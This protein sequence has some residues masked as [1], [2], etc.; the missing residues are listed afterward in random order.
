MFCLF[1]LQQLYRIW[2]GLTGQT[3]ETLEFMNGTLD[4][5]D[6]A[7]RENVTTSMFG[8]YWAS[9]H[10]EY[11]VT[12]LLNLSLRGPVVRNP[13]F[14]GWPPPNLLLGYKY[15]ANMT[16]QYLFD[17]RMFSNFT[18]V[19]EGT[20][21]RWTVLTDCSYTVNTG[22]MSRMLEGGIENFEQA[23]TQIQ[24]AVLMDRVASSIASA[25]IEMQGFGLNHAIALQNANRIATLTGGTVFTEAYKSKNMTQRDIAVVRHIRKMK[26]AL[27]NY[28]V[29]KK[30]KPYLCNLPLEDENWL[31]QFQHQFCDLFKP[32]NEEI[33]NITLQEL[34]IIMMCG[35]K[36]RNDIRGG[37]MRLRSGTRLGLPWLLRPRIR[38][39]AITR[40]VYRFINQLPP[41]TRQA[42]GRRSRPAPQRT[43]P[44]EA[45]R[46][47]ESSDFEL[48]PEDLSREESPEE[49]D[50][51]L[52][53]V[54]TLIQELE[55]ELAPNALGSDFF[56]FADVFYQIMEEALASETVTDTF[57]MQWAIYF[58]I[59]E[60]VASTL[61]YYNEQLHTEIAEG[62]EEFFGL[63][64]AQIILRARSVEGNVIFTR[65]WY[66]ANDLALQNIIRRMTNEIAELVRHTDQAPNMDANEIDNLLEQPAF[67]ERSGDVAGLI[68]QIT[69]G[70]LGA[71]SIELSFRLKFHG[72]VTFSRNAAIRGAVR[73][74]FEN[75]RL[76]R[77]QERINFATR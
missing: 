15:V 69:N 45:E 58:F 17:R 44:P 60:H 59:L 28:L 30:I 36:A 35:K 20:R 11:Q 68:D 65:V 61:Y 49:E 26:T 57:V 74:E 33:K 22:A 10:Y 14:N 4:V 76:R 27:M 31:I 41:R 62:G 24:Q 75:D 56:E 46:E 18:Y 1:I 13:P 42:S 47:E 51:I 55:H 2:R 70:V 66:S 16:E 72:L 77:L 5:N 6:R 32:N 12:Q 40:P 67:Y 3:I 63:A 64:F 34:V 50:V 7:V 43:P 29:L 52:A 23:A 21:R 9:R 19:P 25:S 53:T 37:A 73:E 38:G 48:D 39:R 8:I 71:D 54:H